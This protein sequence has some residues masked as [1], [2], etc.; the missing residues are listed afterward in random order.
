MHTNNAVRSKRNKHG[1]KG[2]P[3]SMRNVPL[4]AAQAIEIKEAAWKAGFNDGVR[5]T[6]KD[7]VGLVNGA[8]TIRA[9]RTA[10]TAM[11]G[12]KDS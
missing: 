1:R 11:L 7:V 3:R 2:V 10:L 5:I 6:L 8:K 9:A 4:A 12:V